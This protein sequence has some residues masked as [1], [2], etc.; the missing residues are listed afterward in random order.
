MVC[1]ACIA[2][3]VAI[4]AAITGTVTKKNLILFQVSLLILIISILIYLYYK[5]WKSCKSCISQS[6]KKPLIDNIK[7]FKER[8]I[9]KF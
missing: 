6:L 2:L 8:Y 1:P 9:D 3:P 5:Y 4:G 7:K